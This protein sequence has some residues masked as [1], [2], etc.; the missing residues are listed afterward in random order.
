MSLLVVL[1]FPSEV[2][3]QWWSRYPV[4]ISPARFR[5]HV[6]SL[7]LQGD[8]RL[9]AQ[10]IFEGY[11]REY[12]EA[13]LATGQSIEWV[14]L[15]ARSSFGGDPELRKLA[16]GDERAFQELWELGVRQLERSYFKQLGSLD[17]LPVERAEAMRRAQLRKRM[18]SST[19]LP[20][21]VP[22]GVSFD[23][24][25]LV[26]DTGQR[27]TD[28][29][30]ISEILLQYELSLDSLLQTLDEMLWRFNHDRRIG[31]K[32]LMATLAD[33]S[34][35]ESKL[36]AVA[37]D[38]AEVYARPY[39]VCCKIR[40]ANKQAVAR[41]GPLFGELTFEEF[42]R[43][44]HRKLFSFM[45]EYDGRSP[46]ALIRAALALEDL[47][48]KQ[49]RAI[50]GIREA[51]KDGRI[52]AAP[53]LERMYERTITPDMY[54]QIYR[55]WAQGIIDRTSVENPRKEIRQKFNKELERWHGTL[56]GFEEQ[57]LEALSEAQ[58]K[59]LS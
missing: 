38:V 14:Q 4:H 32:K 18:L 56:K 41:V 25:A 10:A 21:G 8:F 24:L 29:P 48:E 6:E 46:D 54:R 43:R 3:A 30:A 9:V 49:R 35:T 40:E 16:V 13:L 39:V 22:L 31:L 2:L 58:R 17:P 59:R 23:L 47:D 57:V 5:E 51:V 1:P 37:D 44:A 33:P 11:Q 12:E 19:V 42:H 45:Y 52:T 7:G 26:G 15:P 36:A 53:R 20:E 27:R 55:A 28:A 50:L 34:A